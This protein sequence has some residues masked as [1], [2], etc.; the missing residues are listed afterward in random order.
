MTLRVKNWKRFQH[1]SHRSPPWIKLYRD[2]I[3]DCEYHALPALS[4]K[5]LPLLW[6]LASEKDG[7][8]PSITEI[9]F[10]LRITIDAARKVLSDAKQWV[11]DDASTTLATC[12]ESAMLETEKSRD[13]VETETETESV[14]V[15]S[16]AYDPKAFILSDDYKSNTEFVNAWNSWIQMRLTIKKPVTE[17]A[18]VM[19]LHKLQKFS[20]EVSTKALQESVINSWQGVFPE[21]VKTN[22]NRINLAADA[23]RQ[24]KRDREIGGNDVINVREL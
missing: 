9:A 21:S 14:R 22:D 16:K 10:R 7:E 4:A 1:Y 20:I 24:A 8:L 13:R 23:R 5:Y 12:S 15:K 2:L 18:L 17:A 19:L 11:I 6:I 3:D